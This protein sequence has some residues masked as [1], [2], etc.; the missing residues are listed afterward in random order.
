M[1]VRCLLC[2]CI[3]LFSTGLFSNESIANESVDNENP[4]VETVEEVKQDKDVAQTLFELERSVAI[5]QLS[6]A[7]LDDYYSMEKSVISLRSVVDFFAVMTFI[8]LIGLVVLIMQM[9]RLKAKLM[10]TEQILEKELNVDKTSKTV[11]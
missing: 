8:L 2:L 1:L 4:A 10:M 9:R 6:K 7:N 11:D 5:L 3:G